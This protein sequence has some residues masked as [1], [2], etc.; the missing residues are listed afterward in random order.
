MAWYFLTAD[1]ASCCLKE[2]SLQS[3]GGASSH[4]ERI[5]AA[6]RAVAG[7]VSGT[8]ETVEKTH[9]EI[10]SFEKMKSRQIFKSALRHGIL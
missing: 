10:I 2:S 1:F 4:V 3:S 7:L 5:A 6:C 9:G 8:E